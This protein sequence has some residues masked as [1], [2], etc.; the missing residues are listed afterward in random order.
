VDFVKD[1][2]PIF[3]ENCYTCHGPK[4]Q[5]AQFRLDNKQIALQGGELGPAILP[6][7]S[8]ES[9]L[10]HAVSGVKEDLV[11]PKEGKRLTADQ[12]GLLR[13]WIDQGADWPDSASVKI[14][15]KRNHWAFK[16][17]IRP[18]VPDVPA[19]GKSKN[20][21]LNPI[22]N[23]VLARLEKEGLK[24]SPEADRITLIRRLSLDLTGLP[25]SIKEVDD[26]VA[27]KRPDAYE[28]LVERLLASPHYGERW[29]R[30]WLD[31]ARYADSNGYEKDKPRSIWPYRDWVINALNKEMPFD[32]FTIEQLAGDLLPSATRDQRVATGFLRN[33]MLNQEG[34]IEPEQF[35]VEALIDRMDTLGKAFLGLTIN[36]CQC[37]N[38]KYDPFTQKDYYRLYAFL[39]NDDESFAEV[40]NAKQEKKRNEILSK[41]RELEDNAIKETTNLNERM[42][43]WEKKA[44]NETTNWTVLDPKDW[45]NFA[46]KFEKQDDSSLLGGGDLQPG[47]VMR[48]YVET[49]LTNITGFRL[50]ALTN[51]NLMY[52]GPGL[53]GKGSF[54]VKEFTVEA[55]P[56]DTNY[57][58][59][60]TTASAPSSS[61]S[62]PEERAGAR[63]PSNSTSSITN[64]IK[65]RSALA[66]ATAPGFNIINT[67]DG[68]TER[69][70]WT[71]AVTPDRRNQNHTAIFECQEPVGFPGG[72][73]LAFTIY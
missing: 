39:N 65:F 22:D 69:N 54:L 57:M 9:L 51:P 41:V 67:I 1:I 13:A 36:C 43:A 68:N 73:K 62:P 49:T 25:P 40:P 63:S 5:E 59:A 53:L 16:P 28:Q 50:E 46:T 11:M 45:Q 56:L 42:A 18:K 31:V 72:T 23:F 20:W 48:V 60:A 32:Q 70:G 2:Q 38:H 14:E 35:R 26:F 19:L 55:S 37:H 34:G 33:S 27:D 30:H 3:S 8:A 58:A 52:G 4:K 15:D 12:I 24:P 7:K 71:P 61:P 44:A 21:P 6:G 29:A 64:K 66:D 17:P 47:G 10:I